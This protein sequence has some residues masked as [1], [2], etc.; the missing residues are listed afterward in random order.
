MQMLA[1]DPS[2]RP[3]MKEIARRLARAAAV[4]ADPAAG[5]PT[6]RID[7]TQRMAAPAPVEPPTTTVTLP[8]VAPRA[9][10][11]APA[12]ARPLGPAGP[13]PERR[14]SRLTPITV[15]AVVLVLGLVALLATLLLDNNSG[16]NGT[17]A[18]DQTTSAAKKT[19]SSRPAPRT[20]ATHSQEST[21]PPSAPPSTHSS[22]AVNGGGQPSA[23]ELSGAVRDYY[24][25]LPDNT[26]EAWNRLT[27]EYQAQAGGRQNYDSFWNGFRSVS[28]SNIRVDGGT[29]YANL[30][31][32]AKSGSVSTETRSFRLVRQ[33]GILK[34]AAS[35]V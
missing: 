6:H 3:P 23:H 32:V 11:G 35:Q 12:G 26:G 34:I 22:S 8:A 30:R 5:A 25:L 31:Y 33:D 2:E 7:P 16:G 18:S 15:A 20:S 29:V 9:A 28:T 1:V 10:V 19:P 24:A 17:A 4:V 21:P 27:P 14:R 13:P